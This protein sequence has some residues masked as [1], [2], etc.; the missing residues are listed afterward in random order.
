MRRSRAKCLTRCA[1]ESPGPAE[2]RRVQRFT[3]STAAYELYLKG[4]YYWNRRSPDDLMRS[5]EFFKQAIVADPQYALAYAGLAD[6]YGVLGSLGYDVCRPPKSCP[7]RKRRHSARSARRPTRRSARRDGVR[8]P[9]QMG[10]QGAGAG[11]RTLRRPQ[12]E[13][14]R[15]GVNG[16]PATTGRRAAST[17]P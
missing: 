17:R 7:R 11:A 14:C 6:A 13:L 2:A 4:R 16:W 9:V 8:A 3:E 15:P 5:V 12:S 1:G 10:S